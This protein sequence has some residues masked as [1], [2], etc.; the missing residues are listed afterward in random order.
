MRDPKY[1]Q[2]YRHVRSCS[3][4]RAPTYSTSAESH[5]ATRTSE[6]TYA[7]L[8]PKRGHVR[9]ALTRLAVGFE[10]RPAPGECG[11]CC[12]LHRSPQ[13]LGHS[14]TSIPSISSISAFPSLGALSSNLGR[15]ALTAKNA[16]DA[17]LEQCWTS[18]HPLASLNVSLLSCPFWTECHLPAECRTSTRLLRVIDAGHRERWD[19][20]V[21]V[22][23]GIPLGGCLNA[24]LLKSE[25]DAPHAQRLLC[26][27]FYILGQPSAKKPS[28]MRYTRSVRSYK[29][30]SSTL[31]VVLLL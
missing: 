31:H 4:A 26:Y 17:P 23:A 15:L 29:G 12:T 9:T 22:F 30:R 6:I 28:D 7:L 19:H 21:V 8:R 13:S 24:T 16:V 10:R 14:V 18:L 3:S 2:Y 5:D 25:L 11:Q 27:A 20:A 1:R